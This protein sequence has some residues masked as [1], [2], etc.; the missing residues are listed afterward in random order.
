MA[1]V[2]TGADNTVFPLSM[3]RELGI[4]AHEGKGPGATAFGGQRIPLSY[5][6]VD[7]ELF[8]EEITLRWQG[9]VQFFDFPEAEPEALIVGHE[10]F[11]DFFTA[12]FDGEQTT[13][14]LQPNGGLPLTKVPGS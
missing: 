4:V 3:A 6:D 10:G 14:E 7:L 8:Q 9:R 1:L 13:L 2:D 12:I 11:L 5:A